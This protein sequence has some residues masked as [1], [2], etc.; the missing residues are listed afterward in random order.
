MTPRFELS[1]P[2]Y[3]I[4]SFRVS[5]LEALVRNADDPDVA[6]SLQDCFPH[7]YREEDGRRFLE[8]ALR[9]KREV[10]LAIVEED[11]LI[12]GIGLVPGGDVHAHQAEIGYWL[13]KA[14]WRRGI[15]TR[16]VGLLTDH[17]FRELG[18]LRVWAGVFA[19]NPAS[20]RVLEKNGFEREGVLRRSVRKNG[21]FLDQHLFAKLAAGCAG[22]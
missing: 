21:R 2:P 19:N 11:V 15:A 20:M 22:A 5:D 16:A 17:A 7:P 4:R 3:G 6:A 9:E 8:H 12:G 10:L 14:H 13:G 18:F 1:S